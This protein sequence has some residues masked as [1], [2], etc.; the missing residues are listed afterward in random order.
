MCCVRVVIV[1]LYLQCT[2]KNVLSC[3]GFVILSKISATRQFLDGYGLLEGHQ[4]I[5]NGEQS[6]WGH[7]SCSII[8]SL[9]SDLRNYFLFNLL[10]LLLVILQ[11][12][13]YYIFVYNICFFYLSTHSNS[14]VELMKT[15]LIV[16]IEHNRFSDFVNFKAA[17]QYLD[18]ER[19]YRYMRSSIK[20]YYR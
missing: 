20:L 16:L 8:Y 17:F 11:F 14:G 5:R 10:H 2:K 12:L 13:I 3:D 18:K 19:S 6:N 7:I 4:I 15:F 9:R 1:S